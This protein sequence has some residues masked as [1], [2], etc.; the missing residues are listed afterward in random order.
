GSAGVDELPV[1][2][3]PGLSGDER[4]R[5]KGLH[6]GLFPDRPRSSR[7]GS[8]E[9]D[10]RLIAGYRT[11]VCNDDSDSFLVELRARKDVPAVLADSAVLIVGGPDFLDRWRL[12]VESGDGQDLGLPVTGQK[13]QPFDALDH[14][15]ARRC[16]SC[17]ADR[18]VRHRLVDGRESCQQRLRVAATGCTAKGKKK[19]GVSETR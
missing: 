8:A 18:V 17:L 1:E 11:V 10:H 14:D 4:R 15:T 2:R 19:R 7:F 3:G 5:R 16:L 12:L 9:L 6:T 13:E